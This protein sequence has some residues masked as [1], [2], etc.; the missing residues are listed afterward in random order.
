MAA[1]YGE[2][3]TENPFGFPMWESMQPVRSGSNGE[4]RGGCPRTNASCRF[5]R[6]VASDAQVVDQLARRNRSSQFS[7]ALSARFAVASILSFCR[8][9]CRLAL[10]VQPL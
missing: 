1:A 3:Q 9:S 8:V 2:T 6:F 5:R 4:R 7:V 10:A